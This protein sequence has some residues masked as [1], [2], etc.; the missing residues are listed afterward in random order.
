MHVKLN[1]IRLTDS[2]AVKSSMAAGTLDDKQHAHQLIEHLGP[3]QVAAVVHVMELLLDP[4]S[5]AL[6]NA[7]PEDEE[8]SEDEKCAVAE[9]VESLK[10]NPG[11]PFEH[12][13]AELGFTM[14]EVT[15]YQDAS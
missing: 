3:D 4:V 7:P 14:E 1:S 6:A 12:V 8:I 15:N 10:L 2:Q 13:V 11:I 9:A 5:L